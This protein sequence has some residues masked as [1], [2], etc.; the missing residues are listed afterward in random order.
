MDRKRGVLV[1][2]A[3]YAEPNV[4]RGAR[5]PKAIRRELERLAAWRGASDIEVQ[6][7][8]DAWRPV[9]T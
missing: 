9:L 3:V 8:P 5:L 6:V 7:A 2:P 1:A 4:P